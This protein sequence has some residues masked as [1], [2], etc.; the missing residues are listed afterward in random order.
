MT[1][2]ACLRVEIIA[3]LQ[4]HAGI[5]PLVRKFSISYLDAKWAWP[6]QFAPLTDTSF[7]L[8]DPRADELDVEELRTMSDDLQVH[9]FGV[10]SDGEVALLL[11]EGPHDAIMTFAAMD[12]A[13]A[14]AAVNDPSLLPPGG[15][16][17]R[18]KS[19][20]KPRLEDDLAWEKHAELPRVQI[21]AAPQS[22]P[23]APAASAEPPRAPSPNWAVG[24]PAARPPLWEGVQGVYFTQRSSFYGNVVMYMPHGSRTHLSLL[25]GPDHAPNNPET[26]DAE[27]VG[28]AARMLAYQRS[29]AP[30]YLPLSFSR[31]VRPTLR[32]A[33]QT[34]L[35]DLPV[36]RRQELAAT[37]YDVP[38]DP[39]HGGLVQAAQML[40]PYF[41]ALDLRCTDPQFE[42][43]KL[44]LGVVNSVTFILPEGDQLVRLSAMRRFAERMER[45]KQRRIWPA[46]SNVRR[47]AEVEAAAR[48]RIPFVTGP[49]VCPPLPRPV[50]GVSMTIDQLPLTDAVLRMPRAS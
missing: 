36:G 30:I 20:P 46:V 28:I 40:A 19:R 50:G 15:R 38:R 44:P 7:L 31:L 11:F 37:V 45:F 21:P 35:E 24:G 27:C 41:G 43:E 10:G 23:A 18:L 8:S 32:A 14:A 4:R 22:A 26:F 16:L 48:L 25:D 6:R 17:T 12:L 29:A 49:A 34:L 42:V 9:L 5:G 1:A 39:S 33:Y 3:A 47:R 2:F 13:V